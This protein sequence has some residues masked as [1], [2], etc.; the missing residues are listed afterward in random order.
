MDIRSNLENLSEEEFY[1]LVGKML[2]NIEK[3]LSKTTEKLKNTLDYME[4]LSRLRNFY[5]KHGIDYF[6]KLN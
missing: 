6:S 5:Q 1:N 3:T 2:E 4:N